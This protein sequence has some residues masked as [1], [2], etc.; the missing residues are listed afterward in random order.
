MKGLELYK[1]V[2]VVP[3]E[4]QKKISGGRLSGMTDINPMWRIKVLTEQFGPCG[5]GWYYIPVRKWLEQ[6]GNEVAAFVDIELY[7]KSGDEWSKPISGTGGSKFATKESNGLH[8]SDECYKMATTDAISV[9]CKQLGFGANVYWQA[10]KTKY[11]I[12][13]PDEEIP[14]P[15]KKQLSEIYKE[16]ARTGIGRT[17]LLKNY[18][19]K[20]L[21]AMTIEQYND[22]IKTLKSKPDKPIDP[23]TIP[24]ENADDGTPWGNANGV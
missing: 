13:E 12:T 10:D 3:V 17:G 22:A 2:R 21:E 20:A 11:D 4:A 1:K 15:S 19:I 18:K 8:V 6:S 5:F 24:P 14:K 9:A 7:I 16:L 23:A